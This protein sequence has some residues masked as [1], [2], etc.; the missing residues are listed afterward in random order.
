MFA[1]THSPALL[2]SAVHGRGRASLYSRVRLRLLSL[3]TRAWLAFFLALI[4]ALVLMNV[5]FAHFEPLAL[6][7]AAAA[8]TADERSAVAVDLPPPR[9][10]AP[11]PPAVN[12]APPVPAAA[13]PAVPVA[14]S[15]PSAA[16]LLSLNA[17][18][19]SLWR[20]AAVSLCDR[21]F[22][23]GFSQSA[24]LCSATA[25]PS[26]LECHHNPLTVST[27][28]E[29]RHVHLDSSKVRVSRGDEDIDSVRW[30]T[31]D[32]EFPVYDE[33]ALTVDCRKAPEAAQL[34]WPVY[35]DHLSKL[36]GSLSFAPLPAQCGLVVEEALLVTRYEYANLYHSMTDWYNVYQ[37]LNMFM[38][39]PSA[40]PTVVFLDGHS[41]GGMDAM[42]PTLFS[43][44]V[45]Y[46]KDLPASVCIRH[47]VFVS[48]GYGSAL[49][50]TQFTGESAR[51]LRHPLVVDFARFVQRRF[52]LGEEEEREAVVVKDIAGKDV[53]IGDDSG[54][55]LVSFVVRR[56]YLSH[57]RVRLDATE[58]TVVDEAET[59][60]AVSSALAASSI[61]FHA[62][63]LT[64]M[65]LHTQ[66]NLLYH[67]A[68]LAGLHGAALSHILYMHD[69][70]ALVE[71]MPQGY[72]ARQHFRF[73]ALWSGHAYH[74]LP[75]NQ[76]GNG[77]YTVDR[78]ALT[79]IVLAALGG[80]P[81]AAEAAAAG[82]GDNAGKRRK[83]ISFGRI[84][85][86]QGEPT[87]TP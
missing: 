54:P 38:S 58:R 56:S 25:A 73:F 1:S 9:K 41:K 82:G 66:L 83:G 27:V 14:G 69:D 18:T 24:P 52:R 74:A 87:P 71:L 67:S 86:P 26:S 49:S 34:G 30:R 85:K 77:G 57:P 70:A 28:C 50:P 43:P 23:N 42:W 17:S 53:V 16:S 10:P 48:P 31:E 60:N 32:A 8:A 6:P 80:R 39:A 29:G 76:G 20:S 40:Q 79:N 44:A 62:F 12:A 72:S 35:R 51:C 81:A 21:Q 2:P 75:L 59:L 19:S 15:A 7:E 63:D 13:V 3:T 84:K 64:T 55:P 47:A 33:G 45:R 46:V 5:A 37:A 11:P 68:V 22:G 36:F 78:D 4:S 61:A 65:P